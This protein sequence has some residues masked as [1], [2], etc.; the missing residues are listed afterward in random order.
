MRILRAAPD[1]RLDPPL[2]AVFG[3]LF[4]EYQRHRLRTL[5]AAAGRR[6]LQPAPRQPLCKKT[7][8][9]RSWCPDT[10]EKKPA[11]KGA[12]CARAKYTTGADHQTNLADD[13]GRWCADRAASSTSEAACRWPGPF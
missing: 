10:P 6:R 5:R 1:Y 3:S 9:R 13:R 11:D 4:A 8:G 7:R 2:D 12:R